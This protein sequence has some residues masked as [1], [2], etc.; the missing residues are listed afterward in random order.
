[1][2]QRDYAVPRGSR[3]LVTGANGYI[4]SHIVDVL[5]QLGFHVRGTVRNEKPWLDRLFAEKYGEG[6]FESVIVPQMESEGAFQETI[7]DVAAVIHT[8]WFYLLQDSQLTRVHQRLTNETCI[9]ASDLSLDPDPNV[10]IP[11]VIRGT[12][13]ILEAAAKQPSVKRVVLTSSS[14]AVLV[15][16]PNVKGIILEESEYIKLRYRL[17]KSEKHIS[18]LFLAFLFISRRLTRF[19][20]SPASWNNAAVQKIALLL[21]AESR[22]Q[23]TPLRKRKENERHGIGSGSTSLTLSSIRWYPV[24]MLVTKRITARPGV[25]SSALSFN[26]LLTL[27]L[28]PFCTR[29]CLVPRWALLADFCRACPLR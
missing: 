24:S 25:Q 29:R 27:S 20:T 7:K 23:S 3:V 22:L 5:L 11:K 26:M 8:V 18:S 9:Q 10:V 14:A 4:A 28:D 12:I 16:E 2:S 19:F 13:N 21:R 6:R 15:P 17:R 1:M